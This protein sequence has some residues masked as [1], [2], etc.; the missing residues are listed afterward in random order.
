[1][2]ILLL[3][4]I[5]SGKTTIGKILADKPGWE[6]VEIDEFRRVFGNGTPEFEQIARKHFFNSI[7]PGRDQIIECTGFGEVGSELFRKLSVFNEP[8]VVVLLTTS[9]EICLLRTAARL[10]NIPFP[11]PLNDVE[12]KI[13]KINDCLPDIQNQ[14]SGLSQS[15]VVTKDS[16]IDSDSS[17]IA[18]YIQEI[19]LHRVYRNESFEDVIRMGQKDV[20]D[21]YGNQ[22]S[23]YQTDVI[24][25]SNEFSNDQ[26]LLMDF[27]LSQNI[28]GNIVD[29]GAG[30]CQWFSF[31]E[32]SIHQYIAIDIN[33]GAL[34]KSPKH[35]KLTTICA[36]I[37]DYGFDLANTVSCKIDVAFF[38]FL[39]SHFSDSTIETLLHKLRKVEQIL[40]V[41][42]YWTPGH[43]HKYK[44]NQLLHV[45][46]KIEQNKY[47]YIPKRFFKKDEVVSLLNAINFRVAKFTVGNYWFGCLAVRDNQ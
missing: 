45:R 32:K 27:I 16:V 1:M 33:A 38:S 11:Q 41:D 28:T 22:Y 19:I 4:N 8:I 29:F 40:I 39:L 5:G 23:S 35:E 7:S 13:E 9:T 3:G 2:K 30:N 36:N 18:A 37:F 14:W 21:Y 20:Q 47:I 26:K 25:K 10:W 24:L 42:S 34:S 31:F 43:Q 12:N 44:S 17:Q 6:F 46:R 15:I